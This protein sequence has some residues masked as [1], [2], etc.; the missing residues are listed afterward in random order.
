MHLII[1][2]IG[3]DRLDAVR[4]DE[5]VQI[6]IGDH[7]VGRQSAH[8]HPVDRRRQLEHRAAVEAA[9]RADAAGLRVKD[10]V[11][12]RR[13]RRRHGVGV[14]RAV[15]QPGLDVRLRARALLCQVVLHLLQA[16]LLRKKDCQILSLQRNG[17][18]LRQ[19]KPQ[20]HGQDAADIA[21]RIV[22]PREHLLIADEG[23]IQPR[24][25]DAAGRQKPCKAVGAVQDLFHVT[26]LRALV[27][28][29]LHTRPSVKLL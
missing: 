6:R 10:E 15:A 9:V 17:K 26:K 12:R 16:A 27:K 18:A 24:G 28:K 5:R 1:K 7:G 20:L 3:L 14:P 19:C 22:I 29:H 23:H 2:C 25:L 13:L 21:A 8:A 11:L 4:E